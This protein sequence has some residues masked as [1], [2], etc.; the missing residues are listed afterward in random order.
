M[1]TLAEWFRDALWQWV[2]ESGPIHR[3][4]LALT[5]YDFR[6][7]GCITKDSMWG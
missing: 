1:E 5:Y 7:Q 3:E 4:S 2:R 6:L